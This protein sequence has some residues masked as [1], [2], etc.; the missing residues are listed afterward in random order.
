MIEVNKNQTQS[1]EATSMS[2]E[3]VESSKVRTIAGISIGNA[4]EYFDL[5]IFTF[6]AIYIGHAAFPT[7]SPT[8]QVLLSLA[9]YG[10]GYLVRPIGAIV[11]G[12]YA[13]RK[14]RKKAIN[15]TLMLMAFGTCLIGFAPTYESVGVLSAIWITIGRLIQGFSAGGETGSST[16][17]LAES[18]PNHQRNFYVSWQVASQGMA[19][20]LASTISITL[21]LILLKEEMQS[22]G[23]RIPFLLGLL[24]VPIGLIL[25]KTLSETLDTHENKVVV[26]NTKQVSLLSQWRCVLQGL[27]LLMG[28][29]AGYSIINLY[30]PTYGVHELGL[31]PTISSTAAFIAAVMT[32]IFSPI[33]GIL[34]DKYGHKR[35]FIIGRV[36]LIILIYPVFLVINT[37]PSATTL[38]IG[39]GL[40]SFVGAITSIGVLTILTE[41][42]P[43][44]IRVTGFSIIYGISVALAGGF[45]QFI[46]T[47][48]IKIT[49]NPLSP[50][51]YLI[52][53]G[54]GSLIAALTIKIQSNKE[55]I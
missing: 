45:G 53:L 32:I 16:T 1:T 39:I 40:L 30:M 10:V 27:F 19:V 55:F 29:N 2:N 25:R 37:Y 24:V 6:F 5:T 28:V 42:F 17:L 23:W 8:A 46:V 41:L 44:N 33:C 18:A 38:L 36:I 43:K 9:I 13:D 54:V 31:S 50:A 35:L 15:L 34:C 12:R 11:L 26:K 47:Y 51:F 4:L 7:S 49:G 14:G 3:P 20:L 48:L 21:S 22:W 52:V